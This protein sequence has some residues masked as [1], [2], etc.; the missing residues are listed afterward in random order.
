MDTPILKIS[1]VIPV[2][3]LTGLTVFSAAAQ[4]EP[5]PQRLQLQIVP[6]AAGGALLARP[7]ALLVF[8]AVSSE[9][10]AQPVSAKDNTYFEKHVRPLL[11]ERCHRCHGP[12]KQWADLRLDTASGLRKGGESGPVVV[13]GKPEKSELFHRITEQDVD[14]RMPPEES[15]PKLTTK[16]IDVLT[17]WIKIGAPWPESASQP[18]A[19]SL[20]AAQRSRSRARRRG[21][22][23]C[24]NPLKSHPKTLPSD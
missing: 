23:T 10:R 20:R 19:E 24:R 9:S 17:H 21:F 14:L 2:L 18:T 11:A 7:L 6:R 1:S 13:A 12:K 15:G 5:K 8:G 16:E 22:R 3:G 4:D